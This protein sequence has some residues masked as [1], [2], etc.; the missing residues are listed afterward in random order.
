M[1]PE[2]VAAERVYRGLKQVIL[3]GR[4]APGTM[5]VVTSLAREFGTS[6][7]PVRDSMQRLVGERLLDLHIGGGFQMPRLTVDGLTDLYS[8]H[9][10]LIKLALKFRRSGTSSSDYQPAFPSIDDND[11]HAVA[12]ATAELFL[13]I[14]SY[15]GNPERAEAVRSVCERLHATRIRETKLSNRL[16][17]LERIWALA[18]SGPSRDAQEAVRRYHRRRL[19]QVSRLIPSEDQV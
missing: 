19:R 13:H 5:L 18:R 2:A 4:F 12:E 17:E 8:W 3:E 11:T 9:Q 7:A 1:S 16:H 6:I 10:D 15:S 14:A